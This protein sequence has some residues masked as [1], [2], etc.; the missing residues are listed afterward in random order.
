VNIIEYLESLHKKYDESYETAHTV[1]CDIRAIIEEYKATEQE[2]SSKL[3][4]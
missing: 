4:S 2:I 1:A 3:G